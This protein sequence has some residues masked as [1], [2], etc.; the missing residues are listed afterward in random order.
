[1][2][3]AASM[4]WHVTQYGLYAA[5]STTQHWNGYFAF[6]AQQ[7]AAAAPTFPTGTNTPQTGF[8]S[9]HLGLDMSMPAMKTPA[10]PPIPVDVNAPAGAPGG[11]PGMPPA[12]A[13]NPFAGISPD[14]LQAAMAQLQG[15]K[16]PAASEKEAPAKEKPAKE[17][18]EKS[19]NKAEADS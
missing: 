10:N 6:R 8:T 19:D 4:P 18:E 12:A 13:G 14:Q 9:N 5:G 11:A 3:T 15:G 1:M 7:M 2:Y 16:T 17:K